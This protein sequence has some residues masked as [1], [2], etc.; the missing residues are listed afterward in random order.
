MLA[1]REI[2]TAKIIIEKET[3]TEDPEYT[4]IPMASKNSTKMAG[5]T[6][7]FPVK[8]KLSNNFIVYP[9]FFICI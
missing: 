7:S 3:V 1:D 5:A 2:N 8:L 4:V 6:I 9:R